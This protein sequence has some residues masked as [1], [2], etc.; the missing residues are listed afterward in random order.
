[1]WEGSGHGG[2]SAAWS[3]SGGTAVAAGGDIGR[4]SLPESKGRV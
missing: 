4:V 1:M 2:L 3:S